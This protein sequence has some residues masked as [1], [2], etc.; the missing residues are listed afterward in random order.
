MTNRAFAL[1]V[2]AGVVVLD[3]LTKQLAL[4]FL[5]DGPIRLVGDFL[6]L[7]LLR[8]AGA[9]FGQLQGVGGWIALIAI[10]VVLGIVL[11]LHSI[12][13][14]PEALALGL[15]LGG[16]AGNLVDRLFR[17]PGLADGKV[18]DF[19]DF[20]FW[21]TFNVADSAITIGVA[22]VLLLALRPAAPNP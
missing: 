22:V 17:G 14:R 21:P 18:V 16:A 10:L 20:S 9:A 11:S 3:Q 1:T 7:R 6:Q 12:A 2:A 19:I 13:H 4:T 15:V 8:N 5:S